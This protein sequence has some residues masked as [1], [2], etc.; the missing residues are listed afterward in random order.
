MRSLS[1]NILRHQRNESYLV[2]GNWK[3]TARKELSLFKMGDSISLKLADQTMMK[4][5]CERSAK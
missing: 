2:E 4:H 3:V 1:L 5:R